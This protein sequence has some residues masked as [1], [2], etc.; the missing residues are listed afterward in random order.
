MEDGKGRMERGNNDDGSVTC[1]RLNCNQLCPARE[2]WIKEI[3]KLWD[4]TGSARAKGQG[5]SKEG[6]GYNGDET[7][8]KQWR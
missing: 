7:D 6:R 3:T 1:R 5:H 8:R 2:E 4:R